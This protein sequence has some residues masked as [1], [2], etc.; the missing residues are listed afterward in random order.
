MKKRRSARVKRLRIRW[1]FLRAQKAVSSGIGGSSSP[2]RAGAPLS[3]RALPS[4]S[5]GTTI[6]FSSSLYWG[7][8]ARKPSKC[9][10]QLFQRSIFLL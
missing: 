6:S 4:L 5:G 9:G 1:Q 10:R 2:K 8:F 3:F 7:Q